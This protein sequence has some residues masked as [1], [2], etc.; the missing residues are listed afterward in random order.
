MKKTILV[1]L[2]ALFTL[3]AS[4]QQ[5]NTLYFLE[6]APMRHTINPAFQPVSR[7]YISLSPLGWTMYGF[8]NNSL[9]LSDVLYYDPATGKTI[10]PLHPDRD[11]QAF[12]R[13]M[14]KM[15]LN[16]GYLTMSILNMGFRIKDDGYLTIGLSQ[17]FDAGG[18][19]PKSMFEFLLDGGVKDLGASTVNT[20]DLSGI[21]MNVTTYTELAI[22][23]SHRLNEQ[24]TVGGK[25]KVLA[26]EAHIGINAKPMGISAY[27][28]DSLVLK[29]NISVEA[30]APINYNALPQIENRSIRDFVNDIKSGSATINTSELINTS[31]IASLLIPS[32]FGGAIDIGFTYKPIENLQISAALNDLGFIYWNKADQFTCS[33]DTAYTGVGT[34]DYSDPTFFDANGN[35]ST[36]VL[37]D[38]AQSG[39]LGLVDAVRLNRKGSGY[40][41]MVS[42]KLNVGLDV[43]FWENRI[44]VG[45]LSATRLYNARLYEEVTLGLALRPCNW[46]NIAASYSFIN[47][48]KFSNIG[49]GISLMPYDGLNFT[50]VMDYIPTSYA[51]VPTTNLYLLPDKTKMF[52]LAMGVSICWGSN[53]KDKDKDGVWDKID[54]CPDTPKGVEVDENGCPLDGDKDGVPDYLDLCPNSPI[55]AIGFQDSVGCP[56]D[57]DG[58]GVPDYADMCPGTPVEARGT[59]DINGCMIDSD[60]DGVPDY[61]DQCPGTPLEANGMVDAYGCLLDTDGDGVPDYLDQCPETPAEAANTVDENGC[62][63]DSDN[64][65][66]ADYKDECPDTPKEAL[67]TIDEKGCP[68]DSDGDGVLDYLDKCPQVPGSKANKGCPEVKREVRKLLQKAMQGIEFESGKALIKKKSFPLLDQIAAIFNENTDYIIEIQGHTD[69]TGKAEVN[70]KLSQQRADAVKKYL[71]GKG[72]AEERM[73]AVGYGQEVPVA[74]NSTKEGRQKNRRVEFKISFEEVHVE[75]IL[76]HAE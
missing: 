10:T 25:I 73:T 1:A 11:R 5:V 44:G 59:I 64:D 27:G 12:L 14:K 34:I 50:L 75:T 62:P 45:V 7:G 66:V 72:V 37:M 30:A 40:L 22:G 58:D 47:N 65:G 42:T 20:F 35:F 17:Q 28:V 61:M 54:M 67:G 53:R 33:F 3:S 2:V 16:N 29:G 48:G 38:S 41:K 8:G 69:N 55:E 6:N 43:N 49:A 70:K 39:M 52:N 57:T 74:D 19:L 63:K 26:G 60:A 32:G 31:D 46:F 9:T 21:G 24:W 51:Q 68:K 4:A 56:L 13:N 76:D 15:T 36:Q 71:A 23:Y 18:T